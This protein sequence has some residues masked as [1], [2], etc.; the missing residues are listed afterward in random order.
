MQLS[1]LDDRREATIGRALHIEGHR[2]VLHL[3]AGHKRILHNFGVHLVAV[4]PGLEDDEGEDD[5][6]TRFGLGHRGKLEKLHPVHHL[7]I[8]VFSDALEILKR[9][10]LL[11]H[12]TSSPRYLPV[13]SELGLG[14]RED[15]PVYI[16]RHIFKNLPVTYVLHRTAR[17]V[18]TSPVPMYRL[19]L[20]SIT[21]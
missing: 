7:G 4:R 21:S 13:L 12:L 19:E 18:S 11:P 20:S 14:H 16:L 15:E 8:K 17:F 3:R 5:Y 9:P 6:L 10:V 2:S 1:A